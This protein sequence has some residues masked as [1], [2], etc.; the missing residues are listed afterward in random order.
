MYC[1]G[2]YKP[3]MRGYIH[4]SA[5]LVLVPALVLNCAKNID[6]AVE[7]LSFVILVL[8]SAICWGAS[9]SFHCISWTLKREIQ[10]QKLGMFL[11]LLIRDCVLILFALCAL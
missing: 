11:N 5:I 7:Q 4:A 10:M 1:E 6:E 8:G 3:M 9:A 2:R